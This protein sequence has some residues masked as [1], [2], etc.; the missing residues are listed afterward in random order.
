MDTGDFDQVVQLIKKDKSLV[1]KIIENSDSLNNY[2]LIHK[3]ADQENSTSVLVALHELNVDLNTLDN[4]PEG[5][6]LLALCA[7][8]GQLELCKKYFDYVEDSKF[9]CV[10]EALIASLESGFTDIANLIVSKG[11]KL[12]YIS[13]AGVG[14]IDALDSFF[15]NSN[16][17]RA[18]DDEIVEFGTMA[19][20]K[21]LVKP[22]VVAC[23]N[24]QLE[25]AFFLIRKGADINLYILEEEESELL[26]ASGLHW[27]A[28]FGHYELVKFL[29]NYGAKV[30][31]KDTKFE[32]TPAQWALDEGHDQ[33]HKYISYLQKV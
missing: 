25:A 5:K 9:K 23:K 21:T 3:L 22:L 18:N 19:M 26:E 15:D 32:R 7:Q 31:C 24:G 20:T 14:D 8:S 29:I 27:A 13:S 33:I 1:S 16:N 11:G 12:D 17:L 6:N 10:E 30:Y 4:L 28:K 2:Q